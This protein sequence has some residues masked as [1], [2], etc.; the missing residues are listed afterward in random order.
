MATCDNS[1]QKQLYM[2]Q[3]EIRHGYGDWT[4]MVSELN[5]VRQ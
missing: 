2:D 4:E 3:C 1:E 5:S